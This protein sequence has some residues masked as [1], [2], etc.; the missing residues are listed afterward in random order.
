MKLKHGNVFYTIIFIKININYFY[1]INKNL[2]KFKEKY[3]QCLIEIN[4]ISTKDQKIEELEQKCLAFVYLDIFK[5]YTKYI[6]IYIKKK[7][8]DE[9]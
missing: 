1:I 7:Q 8:T 3:N 4:M 2:Q 6:D 5:I 9:I